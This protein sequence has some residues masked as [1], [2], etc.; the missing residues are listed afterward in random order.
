MK[1]FITLFFSII[2]TVSTSAFD[3]NENR[4]PLVRAIA[5][6]ESSGGIHLYNAREGAYGPLQIRQ[7]ALDDVNQRYNTKITLQCLKHC[8]DTS[9]FVFW[10]Y[11]DMWATPQRIG[12]EP[13]FEDRARIWNGGPNGFRRSATKGYW[14]R[15]KSAL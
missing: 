11:T 8:W 12:R 15:V 1:K 7:I 5:A 6:V 14:N 10:A 13:T 9:E 3:D 2:A 4:H